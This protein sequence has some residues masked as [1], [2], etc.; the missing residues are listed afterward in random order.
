MTYK[1]PKEQQLMLLVA[2]MLAMFLVNLM[3]GI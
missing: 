3:L 1:P 2:V